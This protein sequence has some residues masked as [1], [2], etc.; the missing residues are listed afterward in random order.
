MFKGRH[1]LIKIV[2]QNVLHHLC[3]P[4]SITRNRY[5]QGF[6]LFTDR[7]S[8]PFIKPAS[9]KYLLFAINKVSGIARACINR[10]RPI[11]SSRIV[12]FPEI[13]S[14][15]S[16]A[17][18]VVR[19]TAAVLEPVSVRLSKRHPPSRGHLVAGYILHHAWWF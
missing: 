1:K 4:W 5:D 9:T 17:A 18:T 13:R 14:R 11:T 7:L 8:Y 16:P 15:V 12:V 3:H 2:A 10:C 19:P 6:R